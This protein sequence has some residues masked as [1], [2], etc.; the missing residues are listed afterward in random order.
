VHPS[1]STTDVPLYLIASFAPVIVQLSSASIITTE[2]PDAL[3][4]FPLLD[5][6]KILLATGLIVMESVTEELS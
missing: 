4:P 6:I 1:V 3:I 5:V 2:E